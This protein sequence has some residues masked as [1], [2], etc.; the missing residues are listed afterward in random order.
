MDAWQ[1][2]DRIRAV[3]L[4]LE[5]DK[6]VDEIAETMDVSIRTLRRWV[7]AYRA[8]GSQKLQPL[9]PGPVQGTKS[10]SE[11]IKNRVI[12]LKQRHLSWGARRIKYQYNLPCHW[13]TVHRIIKRHGLLVRIKPKPQPSRRFQRRYVDSLWQGDTFQFRISGVGKVY[14]TGFTDDR[15]RY[16]VKSKAYLHRR[17]EEAINAL[18]HALKKGRIP[19]E[20][21]LDNGRQFV[22]NNFR[23]ELARFHIRPVYGRPYHPRGRGK[24]EG[25]HKILYRE[26]ISQV[27][28]KSLSHFRKELRRFD[29]RYNY[30]R[31]SQALGWQTPASIYYDS[32]YRR[33]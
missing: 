7:R 23:K 15:S 17:A 25:Y 4:Y 2:E 22:S 33:T 26:L 21:Y 1:L 30:W 9:K 5:Y 31:K 10:T 28:F 32:K 11:K 18:Y 6:N 19:K 27:R 20:M 8:G 24:I 3:L 12:A 16:R 13:T 14:V 29:K